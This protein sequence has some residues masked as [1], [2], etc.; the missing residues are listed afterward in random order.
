MGWI[1]RDQQWGIFVWN[2][3]VEIRKLTSAG[4]WKHV[5]GELNPADLPSRCSAKKFLESRWWKGPEWLKREPENWPSSP[6]QVDKAKFNQELKKCAQIS[7]LNIKEQSKT[8]IVSKFSSYYKMIRFFA[9]MVRFKNF[10]L[11]IEGFKGKRLTFKEIQETE[12]KF[13]KS[14]QKIMFLN[15]KD[16]KLNSLPV[17]EYSDGLL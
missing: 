9:V 17:K 2:R 12:N 7:L 1:Q 5:P 14:L 16:P 13:L 15:A 8:E 6:D 3:V 11:K 10:K 4:V